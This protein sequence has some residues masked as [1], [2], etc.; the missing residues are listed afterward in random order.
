MPLYTI[1][2]YTDAVRYLQGGR[3]K[4]DRPLYTGGLRLQRH[5]NG[6]ICVFA[7]W[8]RESIV[9]IHPNDVR[10]IRVDGTNTSYNPL[11]SQSVRR[12]IAQYSG[13]TR[14]FQKKGKFYIVP[15]D[16]TLTP[17]KIQ[18]C[19]RCS[20]QGL[21][22]SWCMGHTCWSSACDPETRVVTISRSNQYHHHPCEHGY[23]HSHEI[24]LSRTCYSCNGSGKMDYGSNP[25]AMLWDG[26]PLRLI[27]GNPINS[28]PTDLE[29]AIAA[30]VNLTSS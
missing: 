8:I 23:V 10:T 11:Y 21:I 20:S 24:P 6:D 30:Y 19:R 29:K 28:K 5:S 4:N 2:S 22:S 14:V 12:L 7:T 15:N 27:D 1:D 13:L 16:Y 17:P 26:S 18:K 25:V 9:T 3:N